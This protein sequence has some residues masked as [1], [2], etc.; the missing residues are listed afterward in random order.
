MSGLL[1][2]KE[3]AEILGVSVYKLRYDRWKGGGV[4]YVKLAAAVRYRPE[5]LNAYISS[6]IRK[7]TSDHGLNT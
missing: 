4:P 6:R 3:A 1:K 2:E 5:D 7:S